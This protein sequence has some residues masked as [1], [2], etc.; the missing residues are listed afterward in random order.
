MDN[1]KEKA[2]DERRRR[3]QE[4]RQLA[5]ELAAWLTGEGPKPDFV[6]CEPQKR[7]VVETYYDAQSRVIMQVER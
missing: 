7:R 1:D 5:T 3:A 2:R 6:E 4:L